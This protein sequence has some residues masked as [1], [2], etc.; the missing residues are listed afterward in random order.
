MWFHLLPAYSCDAILLER[1][2]FGKTF[3]SFCSIKAISIYF[4]ACCLHSF[5]CFLVFTLSFDRLRMK[6]SAC[7]WVAVEA[8]GLVNCTISVCMRVPDVAVRLYHQPGYR[9]LIISSFQGL[10]CSSA[11][12]SITLSGKGLSGLYALCRNASRACG[13][14]ETFLANVVHWHC[15][16]KYLAKKLGV[17]SCFLYGPCKLLSFITDTENLGRESAS[18]LHNQS[19]LSPEANY[20]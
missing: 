7:Q 5:H 6:T 14:L 8:W 18:L 20:K 17:C 12:R 4:T 3:L 9:N 2:V 11:C 19:L 16:R 1:Y 13:C 15:C 10:E